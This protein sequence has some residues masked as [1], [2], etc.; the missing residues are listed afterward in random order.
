MGNHRAYH[1]G[2]VWNGEG[3]VAVHLRDELLCSQRNGRRET[4]RQTH[5]VLRCVVILERLTHRSERQNHL[6][7]EE[8]DFSGLFLQVCDHAEGAG[9]EEGAWLVLWVEEKGE[10]RDYVGV[11]EVVGVREFGDC[12]EVSRSD[13]VLHQFESSVDLVS[14]LPQVFTCV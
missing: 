7:M 6:K 3:L 2:E 1:V 4:P 8:E 10:H 13:E 14:I 9:G 11:E 12:C 5:Q